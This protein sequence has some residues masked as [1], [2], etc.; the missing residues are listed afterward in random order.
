MKNGRLTGVLYIGSAVK[1]GVGFQ[2]E[3]QSRDTSAVKDQIEPLVWTKALLGCGCFCH[4]DS[5]L[6]E[7]SLDFKRRSFVLAPI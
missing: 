5:K 7:I 4:S 1:V 6:L 3:G 2:F